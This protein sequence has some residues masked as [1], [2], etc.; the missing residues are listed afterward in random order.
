MLEK[1]SVEQKKVAIV[2]FGVIV[3]VLGA[4]NRFFIENNVMSAVVV[5]LT[6]VFFAVLVWFSIRLKL[7]SRQTDAP[8]AKAAKKTEK[9]SRKTN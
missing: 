3:V 8:P 7:A 1:Y 5:T 6:I 2:V 4:V 9:S